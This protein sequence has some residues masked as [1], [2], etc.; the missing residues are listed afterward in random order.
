MSKTRWFMRIILMI[1]VLAGSAACKQRPYVI[2][3]EVQGP[4]G[5]TVVTVTPDPHPIEDNWGD[6]PVYAPD[7]LMV[8]CAPL[9]E[10]PAPA[11][12]AAAAVPAAFR[13]AVPTHVSP[14]RVNG[15][16]I[17]P[18]DQN[19]RVYRVGVF[20][21]ITT[22]NFWAASGP[23]NTIWNSYMLPPRLSLYTLTELTFQLVPA[24]AADPIPPDFVEAGDSFVTEIRLRDDITWSDGTP[25]TAHDV[26]FTANTALR[27]GLISGDWATWFDANYLTRVEAIDDTTVRYVY[28]TKPGWARHEY[29]ALQAP[30]MSEAY[31]GPLVNDAAAPI[32][33]LPQDPSDEELYFA[34]TEATNTLFGIEPSGEPLAGAFLFSARDAGSSLENSANPD[35]YDKGTTVTYYHDGT[36]E[37]DATV[38]TYDYML[39]G[40]ANGNETAG[41]EIGPHVDAVLYTIYG[42]QEAALLALQD[43]EVDFVLN[44]LGLQRGLADRVADDPNLTVLHN[45]T[46]SMRYL[47]FNVRRVPMHDCAFRQAV[48]VLIDKEFVTQTILQGIAFPQYSFVN[49]GNAAWYSDAAPH[50]GEGQARDQRINLAVQILEN[51]GYTWEGDVKPV[52]D[53][54]NRQV[55]PGGRLLLPESYAAYFQSDESPIPVP[56]LNLY[57]PSAGYDPLRSTFAIWIETWLNEVGIPVRANLQGFNVLVPRI[58][59][60]QDFDMYILGWSLGIFP[61]YLNDFFDSEQAVVDGN[62]AGGYYNP[63]FDALGDRLLTC[64]SYEDC[65]AAADEAQM[66]LATELPYVLLFDA[67]IVEVYRSASVEFPYTEQLGG[68]QFSHQGGGGLQSEVN[69]K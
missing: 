37:H 13:A 21:D 39:Y 57:A 5:V 56:H 24:V 58:F 18:P 25:L 40:Q 61:T 68:L 22:L 69:V 20:E 62:N 17:A 9:P 29:G 64:R 65:K 63:A 33:A 67:G 42:S 41:W 19:E 35:F 31:W 1:T 49:E 51:A 30:I 34:Q 59:T 8:A 38:D 43:G 47:S 27:F 54:Q 32:D 55:I 60:E 16:R 6:P 66:M 26:A 28:H 53:E 44:S 50:I 23:D 48:A 52:W 36:F 7:D 3:D 12:G 15:A 14:I 10:I 11:D 2:Y 4:E 46:N 45:P